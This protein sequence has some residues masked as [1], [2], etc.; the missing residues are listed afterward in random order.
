MKKILALTVVGC[1]LI[2]TSCNNTDVGVIG[3]E[4]G[5]TSIIVSG[6][7]KAT[8]KF[9]KQLEKR[10]IRMFNAGGE[11]YYDTGVVN[12]TDGRCGTLSGELKKKAEE[13]EIPKNSGEANFDADGYQNTSDNTKKVCIDGEWIIFKKYENR[14]EN[15]DDYKYVFYMK[16]R[17]NNAEAD[18]EIV[19]LTDDR[20][21]TFNDVYE[22]ILS[23]QA[24]TNDDESSTVFNV[25]YTNVN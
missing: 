14:P 1:C 15:L 8:G 10:T 18:S 16:G 6:D 7:K 4:D 2:L 21:I 19:V 24:Y 22:P 12:D 13:N 25:F 5:P 3:G 20:D 11:L 23:S 17:L 9:G